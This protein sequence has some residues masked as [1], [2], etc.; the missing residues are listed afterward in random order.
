V[1][2]RTDA[3]PGKLA[4]KTPR[5]K[6]RNCDETDSLGSATCHKNQTPTCYQVGEP[7]SRAGWS[8]SRYAACCRQQ[9]TSSDVEDDNASF[10]LFFFTFPLGTWAIVVEWEL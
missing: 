5:R 10:G 4:P 1:Q 2:R 3:Q 9:E 8:G 7:R 6:S